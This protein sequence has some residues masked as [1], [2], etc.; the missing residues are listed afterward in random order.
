MRWLIGLLI[1]TAAVA[2]DYQPTATATIDPT[3]DSVT[4]AWTSEGGWPG[5][6]VPYY[7]S[8]LALDVN[9]EPVQCELSS[10]VWTDGDTVYVRR[11][12]SRR[13]LHGEAMVVVYCE[14]GAAYSDGMPD[15]WRTWELRDVKCMNAS[16]IYPWSVASWI[17]LLRGA[18]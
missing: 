18:R 12:L 3:G 17:A 8:M 11:W 16:R 13:V 7:G 1:S 6:M 15:E 10:H 14:A 9:G 5:D 2:A 4:L